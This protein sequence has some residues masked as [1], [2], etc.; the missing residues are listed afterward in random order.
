MSCDKLN[1]FSLSSDL[2]RIAIAIQRNS[3]QVA[4]KFCEEAKKWV[5]KINTDN[6]AI[7]KLLK[8]IRVS[9]EKEN[10]LQKA[11]DCLMYSTLLQNRAEKM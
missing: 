10:D 4:E 9:L 5:D 7:Q 11:E 3:L 2:K 8:Q 1:L 6:L